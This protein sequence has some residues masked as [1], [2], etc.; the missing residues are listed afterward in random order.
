[1]ININIRTILH[2]DQRY[3]TVGDYHFDNSENYKISVSEMGNPHYEFLVGLHEMIEMYLCKAKGIKEE[4]ITNFDIDFESKREAGNTDEPGDDVNAPYYTEHQFATSI[5]KM[6]AEK[7]NIDWA[8]YDNYV[9][10]L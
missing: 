1:M 2:Q 9:K 4:D 5:E 8:D 3:P 6:M 10:S 7:L